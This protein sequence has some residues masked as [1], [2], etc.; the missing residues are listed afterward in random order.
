MREM[1]CPRRRELYPAAVDNSGF[2]WNG[3]LGERQHRADGVTGTVVPRD[4]EVGDIA[5][6]VAALL[7]DEA[8]RAS[9]AT[10]SRARAVDEFSYDVLSQRLG[11]TLDAWGGE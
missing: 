2:G 5:D 10:A 6:T 3:L 4:A 9:M 8:R 7:T 11:L 1:A